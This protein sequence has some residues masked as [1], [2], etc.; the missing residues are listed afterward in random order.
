[1]QCAADITVFAEI[2][3][4]PEIHVKIVKEIFYYMK[5]KC[6]KFNLLTTIKA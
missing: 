5:Y 4:P 2:N 6:I 1:M 3:V